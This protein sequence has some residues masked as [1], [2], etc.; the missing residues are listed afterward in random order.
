M[1][2]FADLRSVVRGLADVRVTDVVRRPIRQTMTTVH[3]E[4]RQSIEI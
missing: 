2:L 4:V 3:Q 1:F